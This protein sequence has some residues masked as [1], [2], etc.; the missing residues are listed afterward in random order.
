MRLV[1][2][3]GVS[4]A[5][6]GKSPDV[7][8]LRM[9]RNGFLSNEC[10]VG[11]CDGV[12]A[13]DIQDGVNG[14]KVV[15]DAFPIETGVQE[16]PHCYKLAKPVREDTGVAM[17]RFCC[18]GQVPEKCRLDIWPVEGTPFPVGLSTCAMD[19]RPWPRFAVDGTWVVNAGDVFSYESEYIKGKIILTENGMEYI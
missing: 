11:L 17:V 15:Y 9:G 14:S 6:I 8:V 2:V 7:Y 4:L 16:G 19:R 18:G 10:S 13:P 12:K 1:C 3:Q 5:R